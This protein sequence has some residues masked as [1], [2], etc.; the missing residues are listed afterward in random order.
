MR[1]S[2]CLEVTLFIKHVEE[3]IIQNQIPS[4]NVFAMD[5]TGLWNGNVCLRTY[6]D[7]ETQDSSVISDCVKKRDT[8]IV[9]ISADG[10]I[11]SEFIK[12]KRE[13]T[14]NENGKKVV[15]E[16]AISGMNIEIM[17]KFASNFGTKFGNPTIKTVLLF[18]NLRA[19]LNN[20]VNEV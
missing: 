19:H 1:P 20:E 2:L 13:K 4:S 10:I 7:P 3:Y 14:R 12:H 5:E 17:K 18:D 15:I 16:N 8:G 11:Y 6:V 9:A